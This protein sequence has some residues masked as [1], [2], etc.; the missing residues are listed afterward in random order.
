[1]LHP[2]EL[3]IED[4]WITKPL[5]FFLL[6]LSFGPSALAAGLKHVDAGALRDYIRES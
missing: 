5:A 6:L 3:F 2:L 1:M 4:S